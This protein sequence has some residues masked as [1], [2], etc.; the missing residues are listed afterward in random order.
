[1]IKFIVA[2]LWVIGV[3]IG[4]I[5]YSFQSAGAK[6]T[7][8]IPSPL[9]GGLD[10]I[11]TDVLSVPLIRDS[12]V[13]GYFITR[14]VYTVDPEKMK[15]M[16]VPPDALIT[17]Q[18]YQY[19]Y[20]NPQLDFAHHETLDVNAFKTGIRDAINARIEHPLVQEVLVEQIDFLSKEEIRDNTIRRFLNRGATAKAVAKSFKEH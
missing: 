2:T 1:M 18:V 10:Y 14:L 11:K 4:A 17:D 19:I 16:S 13:Q 9:L 8:E 15:L 20:S 6:N 5:F 7:V 3:T 12:A